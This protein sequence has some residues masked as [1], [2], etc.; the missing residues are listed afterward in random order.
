MVA[1]KVTPLAEK[2]GGDNVIPVSF[3]LCP[4]VF[5]T[6]TV[7]PA[8][9]TPT[10]CSGKLKVEG[11]TEDAAVVTEAVPVRGTLKVVPS[12]KFSTKLQLYDPAAPGE[13]NTE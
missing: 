6:V 2:L 4:P 12:L 13:K 1:G 10:V 11:V 5:F 7:C 3:M 8:L 9:F